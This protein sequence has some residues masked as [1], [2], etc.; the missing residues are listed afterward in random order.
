M[1]VTAPA[2]L[3]VTPVFLPCNELVAANFHHWFIR[4]CVSSSIPV[5]IPMDR[6][7]RKA[8]LWKQS[9]YLVFDYFGR[10]AL[11]SNLLS[12]FTA[13]MVLGAPTATLT[14]LDINF[15]PLSSI[16]PLSSLSALVL[17]YVSAFGPLIPVVTAENTWNRQ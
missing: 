14:S 13:S 3:S 12:T 6:H 8:S 7:W 4:N 15:N 2:L 11:T 5:P 9:P 1:W 17:L 16:A 10:R